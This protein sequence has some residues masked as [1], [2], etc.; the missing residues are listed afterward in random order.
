MKNYEREEAICLYNLQ[1]LL[2]HSN[3][4]GFIHKLIHDYLPNRRYNYT[5]VLTINYTG[6]TATLELKTRDYS[7]IGY[8]E[9]DGLYI[10]PDKVQHGTQIYMNYLGDWTYTTIHFIPCLPI[11]Q[12]E[13]VDVYCRNSG[14]VEPKYKLPLSWGYTFIWDGT[15]FKMT[16]PETIMPCDRLE[17]VE[18]DPDSWEEARKERLTELQDYLNNDNKKLVIC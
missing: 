3:P 12:L 16:K 11:E 9:R 2:E 13:M 18:Y 15:K 8:I 10:E 5:D 17:P 4:G 1:Q 7:N 6:G 14:R